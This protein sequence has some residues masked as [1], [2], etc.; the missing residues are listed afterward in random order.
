MVPTIKDARFAERYPDG[1]DVV[2][3]VSKP[4][5]SDG[6]ND[7]VWYE[8]WTLDQGHF[9]YGPGTQNVGPGE[10]KQCLTLILNIDDDWVGEKEFVPESGDVQVTAT[11]FAGGGGTAWKTVTV[12]H[13]SVV[14]REYD[15]EALSTITGGACYTVNQTVVFE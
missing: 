3:S 13:H 11:M 8:F 2:G 10:C 7:I 9:E 12:E 15:W 5:L 1:A 4:N 6:K 14:F